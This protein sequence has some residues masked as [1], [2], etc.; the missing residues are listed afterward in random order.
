VGLAPEVFRKVRI[1]FLP[2]LRASMQESAE[3]RART[4]ERKR[5]QCTLRPARRR[6]CHAPKLPTSRSDSAD[7]SGTMV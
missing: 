3:Y 5:G 4:R 1:G 6:N 7:G 2:S